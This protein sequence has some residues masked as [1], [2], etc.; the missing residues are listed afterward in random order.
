VQAVGFLEAEG[1]IAI[2]DGIDV[3]T[4][5]S[6]IRISGVAKLGGGLMA[7]AVTGELAHVS[8]AIEA[9]ADTIRAAHGVPARAIVFANPSPLI[10]ALAARLEAIG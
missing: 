6:H 1:F 3:M 9:G 8:E 4:K 2:F 10:R 5:S 7:V